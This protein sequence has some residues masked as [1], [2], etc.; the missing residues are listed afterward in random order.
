MTPSEI[1]NPR[2]SRLISTCGPDVLSEKKVKDVKYKSEF[3]FDY[4]GQLKVTLG[5]GNRW[6]GPLGALFLVKTI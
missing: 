5:G 4:S 3:S 1:E 2:A 6:L